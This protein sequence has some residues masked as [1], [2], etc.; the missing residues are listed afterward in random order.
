MLAALPNELWLRSFSFLNEEDLF[1]LATVNRNFLSISSV[2]ELWHPHCIRRWRGKQNVKR[3]VVKKKDDNVGKEQ[4][5]NDGRVG[6]ITNLMQQ[7]PSISNKSSPNSYFGS[8]VDAFSSLHRQRLSNNNANLPTPALNMGNMMHEPKYWK[9][10][11]ILAEIDSRRTDM[12]R[13]ELVYFKWQ[14]VYNDQP[15]QMGLR[16][17]NADGTYTS[18]YLGTTEWSLSNNHLM[19]AG[20][21]LRVKKNTK[22]WGYVIGTKG[23]DPTIYYSVDTDEDA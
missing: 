12:T 17:F 20:M 23:Q 10:S 14:L 11:W 16:Q 9:E 18:A 21:S 6:Y 22:T 8:L 7:Y 4:K 5:V 2:D 15:S 19:F 3:F 13:E 1:N